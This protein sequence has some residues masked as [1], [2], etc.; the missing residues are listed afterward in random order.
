MQNHHGGVIRIGDYLYGASNPGVLTCIDYRT[1]ETVW[2]E[3]EPGKCS[4]LYADGMLI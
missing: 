1:G 2:R 3:R 4:I